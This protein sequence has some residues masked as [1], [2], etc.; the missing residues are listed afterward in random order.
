[1]M[2]MLSEK[3]IV[4]GFCPCTNITECPYTDLDGTAYCTPRP[5]GRAC[6]LLGYKHVQHV[7]VLNT[8]DDCN[9]SICG[10]RQI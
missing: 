6:L 7:T 8:I 9:N 5:C 4:N 10:S 2:V 3:C 1:M